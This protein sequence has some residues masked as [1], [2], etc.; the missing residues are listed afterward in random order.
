MKEFHHEINID[1]SFLPKL[2]G[3]LLVE[4][5]GDQPEFSQKILMEGIQNFFGG[6]G[7]KTNIYNLGKYVLAILLPDKVHKLDHQ[8]FT[9]SGNNFAFI[10]GT[11]YDFER[12]NKI[13]PE[14]PLKNDFFASEI[15][16]IC[17]SGNLQQLKEFN[18]RYSGF[19]Y[20]QNTDT[21]ILFC[22]QLGGNRIYVYNQNENFAV[23]NNI[24]ALACNPCL[25]VSIDE[26]SIAEILQLEYPLYRST[27]FN[28]IKL[29]LPSD[30][31]IKNKN[32]ISYEKYFQK[33]Y[34]KRIKSDKLYI[35]EL[36]D[37]FDTFF[38]DLYNYLKEPVGIFMSKGKDSRIFLPFLENNQIPYIP[39]VF[40]D[41]T[42]V[43]DYPY[44]RQIAHLLDKD[45]HVLE[46]YVIDRRFAFMIAM[47][48]TPTF[49][50]GALGQVSSQYTGTAL[51]GLFGDM[52]SGKMP[53]F[54]VPG[55]KTHDEMIAGIF[56]WIT[57]GVT[58]DIFRESVPY[59]NQFDIWSRYKSLYKEYPESELLIDSEIYHDT[60]NR[61]FRN[62][63]PILLRSQHFTTPI[64]PFAEKSILT[65][66]HSLPVSLIRSQKAH[67]KIA[68][69]EKK[70]NS[71]RTTA[72]PVSLKLEKNIRPLMLEIIKFNNRFNNILLKWQI[73]KFNPYVETDSFIPR[74]DYF[75]TVFQ[76][77]IPVKPTHKR[78]LT[79]M[80]NTDD[81][82][83]LIFHDNIRLFCNLP[84]IIY[85]EL[86]TNSSNKSKI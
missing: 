20:I 78:L 8:S 65:T 85:N 11:F 34:R 60:D 19:A 59:Y 22:D 53:S 69:T 57:K 47:S 80:Y 40:K 66:Y 2:T 68:A 48:T 73:K 30:I 75:K 46:S 36:T 50:W 35:E 13:D 9:K 72:F 21:L 51:M 16:S 61:S 71:I 29:I 77:R 10:E 37:T 23:S 31:C 84:E 42:G 63:Q 49:S 44:V 15:L 54:R 70:T 38:K 25:K 6:F 82:L 83:H 56:R 12:L 5:I 26:Q 32:S 55:I 18:G 86:E 62:T 17:Q 33:I 74:S 4:T 14:K 43:F 24:F 28:E 27:E 79:R 7:K 41:G 64:T 81:Y 67:A 45:L 52:S 58:Q 1:Q 76:G 39:F 3:Y